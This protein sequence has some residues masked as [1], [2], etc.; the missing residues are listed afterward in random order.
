MST[1]TITK[2]WADATTL[3]EA[4]LDKFKTD[5]ETFV[6]TTKL[7]D[8]NFQN[9]GITGS[10]KLAQGSVSA[11]NLASDSVTTVKIA[12]DA[13]TEGKINDLAVTTAKLAANAVTRAKLA[14]IGET[15]ETIAS[16]STDVLTEVSLGSMSYT[17]TGRPVCIQLRKSSASTNNNFSHSDSGLNLD[18]LDYELTIRLYRN[19]TL[20]FEVT[21]RWRSNYPVVGTNR[22][23]QMFIPIG[24]IHHVDIVGAGTYTYA[25]KY[26]SPP[27]TLYLGCPEMTLSAFEL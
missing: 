8:D 14:A 2:G 23:F 17:S 20:I 6:N 24:A 21:G 25:L 27:H 11:G 13:V 10:T 18:D 7:D 19:A 22:T 1:L 9:S 3:T 26:I 12:D 5:T 16:N 4:Q 15:T